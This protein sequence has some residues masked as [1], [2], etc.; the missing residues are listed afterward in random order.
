M[1]ILEQYSKIDAYFETDEFLKVVEIY[2]FIFT[3]KTDETIAQM[4]AFQEKSFDIAK[5]YCVSLEKLADRHYNNKEFEKALLYY[6]KVVVHAPEDFDINANLANCYVQ[7]GAKEQSIQYFEV[8]VKASPF[9]YEIYRILGDLYINFNKNP[10]RAIECYEMYLTKYPNNAGIYNMLGHL[11]N[12]QDMTR[13]SQLKSIEAYKKVLELDPNFHIA[14]FNLGIIYPRL[15]MFKEAKEALE[16]SIELHPTYDRKFN[17]ACLNIQ[18]GDFSTGWKQYLCRFSKENNSTPYI[19]VKKPKWKGQKI[20]NKTL[21]VQWEQG[22]GDS[23]AFVRYIPESRKFA[24]KLIYRV[25]DELYEL[26]NE[27]GFDFEIAKNST[28]IEKINFD[29]HVPTMNLP[30]I[31]NMNSHEPMLKSEGYLKAN[32]EKIKKFAQTYFDNNDFKIGISWQGNLAG[33]IQRNMEIENFSQIAQLPNVKMYSFQKSVDENMFF[34]LGFHVQDLGKDFKNFSDTAA[35]MMNLD[36]FISTDNVLLNLAGAL[37]I[38]TI[39]LL[40]YDSEWRWMDEDNKTI[41]YDS[42]DII[43]QNEDRLWDSVLDRALDY[44]KKRIG[45]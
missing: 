5:K 2:E 1:D 10:N 41:W 43:K 34:N 45:N 29:Y 28:P 18:M 27:Q 16:K 13:E 30:H 3:T 26:M 38:Q 12:S 23:V 14:W 17:L 36:L 4:K 44:V 8:A 31:F 7:T 11:Y 40:N 20:A 24:K 15:R 33:N 25:Q 9:T 35:A 42:V 6:Q 19:K 22:F 32:P 21:L 39:M 37:G